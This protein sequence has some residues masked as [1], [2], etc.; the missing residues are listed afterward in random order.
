MLIAL[1]SAEISV[2]VLFVGFIYSILSLLS[3]S[4]YAPSLRPSYLY[5]N[6][7]AIAGSYVAIFL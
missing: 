1:I 6:A 5:H 4:F 2:I 3:L 7:G